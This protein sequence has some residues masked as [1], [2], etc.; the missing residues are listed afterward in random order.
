MKHGSHVTG[1]V[2]GLMLASLMGSFSADAAGIV[3]NASEGGDLALSGNWAGGVRPGTSDNARFR[4]N[5][6]G[7]YTLSE[8][9]TV[10]GVEVGSASHPDIS[11]VFYL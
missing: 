11:A 6:T 9:M 10:A 8:D 7:E 3:W 4:K 2:C 5:V 1:L